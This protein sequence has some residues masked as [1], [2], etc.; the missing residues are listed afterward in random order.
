[1]GSYLFNIK[2]EGDNL[3]IISTFRLN[4]TN[5]PANTYLE[6]KAFYE[7]RISKENEKVVLTK[8]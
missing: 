6:L 3:N 5:I 1:M 4:T 8:L 7:Q 2:K